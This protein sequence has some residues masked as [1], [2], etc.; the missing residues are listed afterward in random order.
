MI[1]LLRAGVLAGSAAALVACTT[2]PV[3]T[4]PPSGFADDARLGER[5]DRI[6]FGRSING[7]GDTTDRTIIVEVGVNRHYLIETFSY[8]QGL[9]W[10]Q[11]IALDQYASCVTTSDA[12]I[13]S[14]SAFGADRSGLQPQRCPIKAIY[15]WDED[16]GEAEAAEAAQTADPAR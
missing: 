4:A 11:S 5:V 3:D 6:C 2:G 8:C 13:P 15:E 9:D 10:A 12:I 14:D 1:T 7:F 16:A